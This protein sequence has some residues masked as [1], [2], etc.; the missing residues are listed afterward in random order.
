MADL[1]TALGS[2]RLEATPSWSFSALDDNIQE[3]RSFPPPTSSSAPSVPSKA[4]S[5]TSPRPSPAGVPVQH[6]SSSSHPPPPASLLGLSDEILSLIISYTMILPGALPSASSVFSYPSGVC[7]SDIHASLRTLLHPLRCHPRLYHIA[8]SEF[9]RSNLAVVN[10]ADIKASTIALIPPSGVTKHPVSVLLQSL[11]HLQLHVSVSDLRAPFTQRFSV[12][13]VDI[14][15]MDRESAELRMLPTYCP[16]LKSVH[17]FLKVDEW[18]LVPGGPDLR[19]SSG[20]EKV[21]TEREVRY[22]ERAETMVQLARETLPY[23]RVSVA[24]HHWNGDGDIVDGREMATTDVIERILGAKPE[25]TWRAAT[26][27]L[28]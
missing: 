24:F 4:H 23:R 21:M 20:R 12:H 25:E 28:R 13:F 27:R 10:C 3:E 16:N 15:N 26:V 17:I 5:S 18:Y 11:V 9:L 14:L 22:R 2:L 19:R 6:A 8:R 1:A 7:S